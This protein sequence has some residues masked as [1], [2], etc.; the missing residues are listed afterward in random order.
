MVH[1][2]QVSKDGHATPLISVQVDDRPRR[3]VRPIVLFV[4]IV[5]GLAWF[6]WFAF[7]KVIGL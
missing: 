3:K 4:A 2:Y 1:L 7:G 6:V 5:L